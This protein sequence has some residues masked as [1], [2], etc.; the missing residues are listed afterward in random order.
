MC[1]PMIAYRQVHPSMRGLYWCLVAMLAV[2]CS[3]PWIA[4]IHVL[5]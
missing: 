4:V 2:I 1:V 5:L 3:V